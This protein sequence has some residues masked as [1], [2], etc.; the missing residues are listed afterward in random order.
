VVGSWDG[1]LGIGM[2][3]GGVHV[4]ARVSS[5]C[6]GTCSCGRFVLAQGAD[7][8][9]RLTTQLGSMSIRKEA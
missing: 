4:C 6:S 9:D 2:V 3:V 7:S 8:C 5:L 1:P